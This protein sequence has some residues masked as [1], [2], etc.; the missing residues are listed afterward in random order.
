M[1]WNDNFIAKEHEIR[2]KVSAYPQL[3]GCLCRGNPISARRPAGLHRL[4]LGQ[5][6]LHLC[7]C[8][9]GAPGWRRPPNE[10][11]GESSTT[12]EEQ[13]CRSVTSHKSIVCLEHCK[14]ILREID[15][16]KKRFSECDAHNFQKNDTTSTHRDKS[17][18]KIVLDPKK[19]FV[20]FRNVILLSN[21]GDSQTSDWSS[22]AP[23][24]W[25]GSLL[26]AQ[27]FSPD[28]VRCKMLSK[29]EKN[30]APAP[31]NYLNAQASHVPRAHLHSL[32]SSL[33]TSTTDNNPPQRYYH[34]TYA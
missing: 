10:P 32:S 21:I 18:R 22:L 6:H 28:V 33:P 11:R 4:S 14:P 25:C 26:P 17:R 7:T 2:N 13:R 8:G 19:P 5:Q 15:V 29:E 31:N 30:E 9:I 34:Y 3:E 24:Q 16:K 20:A 12:N 27:S 1:S 23:L